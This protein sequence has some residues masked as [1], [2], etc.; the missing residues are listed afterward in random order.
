MSNLTPEDY[1]RI[2]LSLAKRGKGKVSPNPMVGAVLVKNGKIVGK[3]YHQKAG[4][5]HAEVH[6]F[7]AAGDLAQ[8]AD[9]YINLEPCCHFG[10]TPPCT[11]IIIK[12]KI[13]R[14]FVAMVDPNPLVSGKGIEQL[15]KAGI[16]VRTGL[17]EKEAKRLNEVFIKYITQKIPFVILKAASTLDGKI[18][19]STGDSRWITGE[20]SRLFVH[21]LRNE[22][23]SVLVGIGTVKRDNPLLTT[24]LPR[25]IGKDPHRIVLDTHLSIPLSS[26]LLHVTSRA[27]TIIVAA[28]DVSINK[29]KKLQVMGA[30]ILNIPVIKGRLDLRMLLKELGKMEIT[31]IMIEGGREV[32]TSFLE[33]RLVDKLYLTYGPKIVMGR[34]AVGITGGNGIPLIKD[35]LRVTEIKVKRLGED[36]LIEGYLQK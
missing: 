5:P 25:G 16:Q 22:V 4:E 27:K 26:K 29:M 6:A 28:P 11:E 12:H 36:L 2:A 33:E 3:G 23:D 19:T 20:K 9:L 17:L 32:F 10:R 21:Q 35:A 7:K 15:I 31:S 30:V 24:R 18:A 1:M 14:V 8:G 13:K 34:D